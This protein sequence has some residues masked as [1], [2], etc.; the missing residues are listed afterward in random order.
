M[1]A[2][3]I[4]MGKNCVSHVPV[5]LIEGDSGTHIIRM[6]LQRYEGGVD[7]APLSWVVTAENSMG[8][9]EEYIIRE[10]CVTQGT[11]SMEWLVKGTATACAGLTRFKLTGCADIGDTVIWQSGEYHIHVGETFS[12]VPGNEEQQ[13]LTDVQKLIV[14]VDG[15]LNAV[16]RAGEDA[17]EAAGNA[18]SAASEAEEAAAKAREA[19]NIASRGIE[20]VVQTTS[21]TADGG[22]NVI[23]VTMTDGEKSTFQVMNGRQGSAG[24]PG[25]DGT[26]GTSVTIASVSESTADGGS[27]V[28]TFSDGN[29]VTIRNGSKG[30]PGE[31]GVQGGRGTGIHRI[32]TAPDSYTAA[33]GGFTPAYRV[34]LSTVIS[35]GGTDDVLIGDVII[36]SY[37]TYPVGYVDESYVYLGSRVSIRGAAGA[38][39]DAGPAGKDGATAAQVIAALN[40]ETWVFTLAN[41]TTIEKAVP[42]V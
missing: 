10:T 4:F 6:N 36:Y 7:L 39:G 34:A 35:Q 8:A 33:T 2:R 32:T 29:A 5:T 40:T 11:I 38:A 17:Y 13:Q 20:S 30:S 16:I 27:N 42:V 26:D 41:G 9:T 28:V 3:Q 25:S 31:Q 15:E 23:T 18:R 14:Y 19:A 21:S 37:Y 24:E 22:M 1:A 12:H